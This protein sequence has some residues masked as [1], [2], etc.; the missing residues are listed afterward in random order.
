MRAKMVC[1][2]TWVVVGEGCQEILLPIRLSLQMHLAQTTKHLWTQEINMFF[3]TGAEL[4]WGHSACSV[5]L[6]RVPGW[7]RVTL[8]P[9][10][11]AVVAAAL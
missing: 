4:L 10:S 7:T 2:C 11:T 9:P 1:G 6:T 3:K 5:F 8:G